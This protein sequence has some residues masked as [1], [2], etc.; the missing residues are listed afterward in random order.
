MFFKLLIV[1]HNSFF[2]MTSC[3][4][5]PKQCRHEFCP[6]P[7]L[8]RVR[9]GKNLLCSM[10]II[11]EPTT[12]NITFIYKQ[13]MLEWRTSIHILLFFISKYYKDGSIWS[14]SKIYFA[15]RIWTRLIRLFI[16]WMTESDLLVLKNVRWNSTM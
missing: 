10:M 4:R 11:N 5:V 3:P 14:L 16:S 1:M 9:E 7:V 6:T 12:A 2:S 13:I 15:V 8:C